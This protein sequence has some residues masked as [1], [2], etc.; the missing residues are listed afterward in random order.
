MSRSW[1]KARTRD[2]YYRKAKAEGYRSRAAYKL[3]QIDNRF[4]VLST[5]GIVLDLGASP[6]GWSQVA[7]ERV[8]PSGR[9]VAVDLASMAP[10]EGVTFIRGDIREEVTLSQLLAQL[11]EGATCVLSDMSPMLSGN[12]SLDHARSMELAEVALGAARRVLRSGGNFVTKV[13]QGEMLE[14]LRKQVAK[15]F[16][17]CKG[18]T[19]AAS[20]A[21]SAE[22]YLVA[23]GWRA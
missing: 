8:G 23:T 12:R 10:L 7:M 1:I 5:G 14:D 20:L 2:E 16:G 18:Y 3:I 17:S 6:G 15:G 19:P 21:R 4:H 13:L 9:V 22:S 11:P